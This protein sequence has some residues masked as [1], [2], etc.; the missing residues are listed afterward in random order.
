MK[1][2]CCKRYKQ[3]G[4]ACKKCPNYAGL[5]SKEIK[6]RKKNAKR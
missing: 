6:K 2:S 4:R 3:K 5:S 1:P